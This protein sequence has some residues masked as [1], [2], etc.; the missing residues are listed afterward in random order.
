MTNSTVAH[1]DK[2]IIQDADQSGVAKEITLNHIAAFMAGSGLKSTN[3]VLSLDT[4]SDVAMAA[5]RN[6]I[7]SANGLT[8]SLSQEPLDAASVQVYRNGVLQLSSGSVS[9]YYDYQYDSSGGSNGQVKF[10]TAV[11]NA[12]IMQIRYIKKND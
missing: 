7:L 2:L 5:S 3:G 1:G 9:D 8:A 10:R 12:D 4:I 6:S 11:A